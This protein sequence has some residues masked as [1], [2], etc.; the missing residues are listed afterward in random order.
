MTKERGESGTFPCAK[1]AALEDLGEC[2]ASPDDRAVPEVD[3][4]SVVG[5]L[6]AIC[7][8][9][10]LNFALNVGGTVV[11][12]LYAGNVEMWRN[13]DPTKCTSLRKLARHPHL[14]MSPS[15][16]Y[17]SIAIYELC[18]RLHIRSWKHISTGH[19]R[20][21]LPLEPD[22]Q[23]CFLATAEA[24]RWSVRQL[25]AHVDAAIRSDP[26]IRI[27]RGGVARPGTL[28]KLTRPLE[29]FIAAVHESV[30][31]DA[32]ATFESELSPERT[33]EA[34]QLLQAV[35]DACKLVQ[36]RLCDTPRAL[37]DRSS[38]EDSNL[39][40]GSCCA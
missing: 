29:Q 7:K 8:A 40:K 27:N 2:E 17:R 3:L 16:L 20:L 1:V 15:A 24:E 10:T 36:S 26:S 9:A 6:N 5:Q 11:R 39:D 35:V 31:P 18:E 21:V 28:R 33:R 37:T 32:P 38:P 30:R 12:H 22:Q 19:I 23:A 13:R 25:D 34:V 4:E 14:P